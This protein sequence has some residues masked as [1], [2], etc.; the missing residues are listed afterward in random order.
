[1]T[2]EFNRTV[3]ERRVKDYIAAGDTSREALVAFVESIIAEQELLLD[4]QNSVAAARQANISD[5]AMATVMLSL[6]IHVCEINPAGLANLVD[7]YTLVKD[8]AGQGRLRLTLQ[9]K[10]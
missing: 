6:N 2:A 5:V 10:S 8:P 3:A 7:D 4:V 9:P 1:M